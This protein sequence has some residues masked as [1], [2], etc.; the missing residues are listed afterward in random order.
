MGK[1]CTVSVCQCF[2]FVRVG[3]L[4]HTSVCEKANTGEDEVLTNAYSSR[5]FAS[6]ISI[7]GISSLIS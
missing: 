1:L 3:T 5:G 4:K 2:R 7:I 6:S